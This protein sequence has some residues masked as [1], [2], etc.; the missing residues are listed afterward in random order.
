M[1]LSKINALN[2]KVEREVEKA[3]ESIY[4]KYNQAMLDAI[5]NEVPKGKKLLSQNGMAMIIDKEGNEV[6]GRAWGLNR[7]K[8][9]LDHIALLQYHKEF[10]G[11]FI[12]PY[13]LNGKKLD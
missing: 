3:I 5:A 13:E 10:M 4:K 1:R 7:G 2:K 8:D 9:K 12:L 6:H 11:G